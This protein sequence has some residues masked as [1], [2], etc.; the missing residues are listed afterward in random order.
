V[1][2]GGTS[3]PPELTFAQFVHTS[4]LTS[5][6]MASRRSTS[7]MQCD[8]CGQPYRFRQSRFVGFAQSPILLF[9]VSVPLFLMLIWAIGLTT[10]VALRSF[11]GGVATEPA[12][13]R[14]N[15]VPGGD[16]HSNTWID[17]LGEEN[18][19]FE[20]GYDSWAQSRA[21]LKMAKAGLTHVKKG[22]V[23]TALAELQG[24]E[25]RRE[26]RRLTQRQAERSKAAKRG[27]WSELKWVWA[28]GEDEED[29][30]DE[31]YE[32][33]HSGSKNREA[34]ED[35]DDFTSSSWAQRIA[36]QCKSLL[37]LHQNASAHSIAQ[38]A[39]ASPSWASARF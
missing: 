35:E 39:W 27:W 37:F 34:Q 1:L 8:Q 24:D 38:S 5:W 23:I 30:V 28:N 7:A 16:Y 31:R 18:S 32:D 36:L 3:Q 33:R 25:E 21:F 10:D 6:R 20:L 15:L 19:Y 22:G 2:V 9:I 13:S 11:G 12:S 26:A 4:C 14:W 29:E 17:D